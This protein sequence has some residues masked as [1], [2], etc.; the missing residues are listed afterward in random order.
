M[1][2]N[3]TARGSPPWCSRWRVDRCE[4]FFRSTKKKE[5]RKSTN[6]EMKYHQ[7]TSSAAS[8]VSL[9]R[10]GVCCYNC[11]KESALCTL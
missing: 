6:L 10:I 3:Q 11:Y 1:G 5:S 8:P 2:P 9:W 4:L 7:V